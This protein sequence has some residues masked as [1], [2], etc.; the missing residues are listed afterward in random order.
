MNHSF[1]LCARV[2]S[3]RSFHIKSPRLPIGSRTAEAFSLES[4]QKVP[5][6]YSCSVVT[7]RQSVQNALD[8]AYRTD[9]DQ[10]RSLRAAERRSERRS[11]RGRR[12]GRH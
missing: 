6:D 2:E 9:L 8:F 10:Q 4:G 1:V 12:N 5:R 11:Y 3:S 7:T